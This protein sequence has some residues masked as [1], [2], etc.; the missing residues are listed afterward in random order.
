MKFSDK[1]FANDLTSGNE[2][3]DL[4]VRY[5][6]FSILHREADHALFV[7]HKER[8]YIMAFKL[9]P[10]N[11]SLFAH[12]FVRRYWHCYHY[13]LLFSI[14]QVNEHI[15]STNVKWE[16]KKEETN[17][18]EKNVS[19][20]GV[21]GRSLNAVDGWWKTTSLFSDKEIFFSHCAI[22]DDSK[23]GCLLSTT[24]HIGKKAYCSI[25]LI[26][27]IGRNRVENANNRTHVF[28]LTVSMVMCN[29]SF[30]IATIIRREFHS[31]KIILE[32]PVSFSFE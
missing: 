24:L 19:V 27:G 2:A 25:P 21:F 13:Y 23:V 32:F 15:F 20:S 31:Y 28:G 22:D 10:V 30:W 3:Y 8:I 9:F 14:D 17:S 5:S 11:G 4:S 29:F 6:V 12:S 1:Q 16:W 26:G 18:K 7:L